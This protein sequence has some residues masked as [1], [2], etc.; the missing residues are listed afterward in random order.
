[1][2]VARCSRACAP[3]QAG[4]T[5]IELSVVLC[6]L[7]IGLAIALPSYSGFSA[8]G[9]IS[10]GINALIVHTYL[11][12]SEAIKRNA[13]VVL[14]KS[15]D[16]QSCSS[17]GDWSDGWIIFEDQNKNRSIDTDEPLLKL[18]SQLKNL[19]IEYAAFG[20]NNYITY[21]PTGD[22]R[23]NGTFTI[24][25]DKQAAKARALVLYKTGRIRKTDTRPN[26]EPLSCPS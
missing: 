1:M 26:G 4:L 10:S 12:R 11:A 9:R 7:S 19:S 21:R 15:A 16:Q 14:C 5:L 13:Q 2:D 20:S 8:K 3:V 24:C 6:I 22:T 23:T 17:S 25:D 18:H